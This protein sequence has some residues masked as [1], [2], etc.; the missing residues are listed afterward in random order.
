[1]CDGE[2]W[3]QPAGRER[4]ALSASPPA[5]QRNASSQARMQNR[6]R[7]RCMIAH[8]AGA[9]PGTKYPHRCGRPWPAA[10]CETAPSPPH[11]DFDRG[12]SIAWLASSD[13]RDSIDRKTGPSDTSVHDIADGP[14]YR[15][16]KGSRCRSKAASGFN[17][18]RGP[19]SGLHRMRYN[20]A[21]AG[22]GQIGRTRHDSRA[23]KSRPRRRPGS[24]L[25]GRFDQ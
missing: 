3:R 16:H 22:D 19:G 1:M 20:M 12:G 21:S 8:R 13:D 23:E 9:A 18:S 11:R 14:Q 10:C 24:L 4:R 17:P 15:L 2:K 5:P 7:A 6:V 25:R